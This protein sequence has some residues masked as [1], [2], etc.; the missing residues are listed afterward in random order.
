MDLD[1]PRWRE[2][3]A[4]IPTVPA[5][6]QL[7]AWRPTAEVPSDQVGDSCSHH[8]PGSAGGAARLTSSRG[9]FELCTFS[10]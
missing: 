6:A 3:L 10:Q 4:P 5:S 7:R 8:Q 9:G 2:K 1:G